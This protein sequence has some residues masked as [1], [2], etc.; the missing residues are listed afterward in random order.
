[1]AEARRKTDMQPSVEITSEEQ[2]S[3]VEEQLVVDGEVLVHGGDLIPPS[4]P[5]SAP[6]LPL[7]TYGSAVQTMTA[8]QSVAVVE[9]G[10]AAAVAKTLVLAYGRPAFYVSPAAVLS[11][12]PTAVV[13]PIKRETPDGV[14]SSTSQTFPG[15]AFEQPVLA[16]PTQTQPMPL[17]K[18]HLPPI[19]TFRA[20]AISGGSISMTSSAAVTSLT[21]ESSP[22]AM[23]LCLANRSTA[24]SDS[25]ELH[26]SEPLPL[27]SF[28]RHPP[29]S[30]STAF[31]VWSLPTVGLAADV[32][33]QLQVQAA[34]PQSS[35]TDQLVAST[36]M[37]PKAVSYTH[38]TLPTIYSV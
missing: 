23:N 8:Q 26:V 24:K 19:E 14:P 12:V 30:T 20:H 21:S 25:A 27:T 6:Q 29:T 10:Q 9:A 11:T 2:T 13:T 1:M 15:N 3:N 5:D 34:G 7:S 4:T 22:S 37:K 28:Y 35:A 33:T 18:A 38:L 16:H 32:G 31:P 36:P 17:S